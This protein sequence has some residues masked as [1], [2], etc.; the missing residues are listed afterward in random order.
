M[1]QKQP[2][3]ILRNATTH[4]AMLWHIAQHRVTKKPQLKAQCQGTMPW[5]K[6]Q[7]CDMKHN[8]TAP[9]TS[10]WHKA[11]H[12]GTKTAT[13]ASQKTAQRHKAM[14]QQKAQ[15]HGRKHN[16]VAESAMPWH[17]KQ[18]ECA[19][20][21]QKNQDNNNHK[22]LHTTKATKAK[23]VDC[24]FL[25]NKTASAKNTAKTTANTPLWRQTLHRLIVFFHPCSH[26]T[27]NDTT[28]ARSRNAA[29][30]RFLLQNEE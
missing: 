17:K 5:H 23:Q 14:P 3:D 29:A 6:M 15:C 7:C 20:A 26:G 28:E 10:P 30:R 2:S 25:K 22:N 4:H 27:A 19:T 16:A 24:F 8:A 1:E 21:W 9:V 18:Q 11:Q 12:Y 13:P